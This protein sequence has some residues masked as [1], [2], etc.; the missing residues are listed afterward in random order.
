M[1]NI[2]IALYVGGI[3]SALPT[4]LGVSRASPHPFHLLFATVGW[5]LFALGA[6]VGI[7]KIGGHAQL[8]DD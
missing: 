4:A 2:L 5:P 8:G 7:V 1:S 6:M 3:L